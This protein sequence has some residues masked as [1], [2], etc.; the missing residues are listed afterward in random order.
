[1]NQFKSLR[2]SSLYCPKCR[3]AQPVREKLLL[4][5]PD[6]EL[7]DYLCTNCGSSVGSREIRAAERDR[8]PL[9]IR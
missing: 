6:R 5:L 7:F 9:I 2:A 4:I 8:P 3:V 1:M